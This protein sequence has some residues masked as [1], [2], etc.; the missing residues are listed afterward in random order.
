MDLPLFILVFL[1]VAVMLT[2]LFGT[3]AINKKQRELTTKQKE[4]DEA[5]AKYL[6]EKPDYYEAEEK[7]LNAEIALQMKQL[8]NK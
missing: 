4:Y 5:R 6:K 2:I 8:F 7:R 1:L 3:L